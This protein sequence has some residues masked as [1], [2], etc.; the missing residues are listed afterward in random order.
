M[1]LLYVLAIAGVVFFFLAISF[2]LCIEFE[3]L[4]SKGELFYAICFAFSIK[5]ELLP[6]Q[7]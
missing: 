6:S 4:P 7:G 2:A 3:V 1:Y 5:F